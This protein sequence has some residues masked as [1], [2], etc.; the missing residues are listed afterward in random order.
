MLKLIHM[1]FYTTRRE[2]NRIENSPFPIGETIQYIIVAL[3]ES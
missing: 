3:I 2:N 1:C